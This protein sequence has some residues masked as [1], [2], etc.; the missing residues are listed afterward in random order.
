M[1]GLPKAIQAQLDAAEVIE[2][3]I[4]LELNPE[5]PP[6]QPAANTPEPPAPPA[7][8]PAEPQPAAVAPAQPAQEPPPAA[9]VVDDGAEARY[10][11]LKGK[12]DA[13]VPRLHTELRETRTMV[14]T[15]LQ[16]R[17]RA[18]QQPPTPAAPEQP[19]VSSKD[20]DSFGADL[21]E[22][23]VRIAGQVAERSVAKLGSDLRKEF[24]AVQ[25]RVGQV[26]QRQEQTAEQMFWNQVRALVSDWDAVDLDPR[27]KDWL[28]T[29]PD[30]S[31]L[32]YYQLARAAIESGN[33]EG[34]ARIVG[35]WKESLPPQA[36]ADAPTPPAPPPAPAPT[37]QQELSRQVAPKTS[38]ASPPPPPSGQVWTRAEYEQVYD[39]RWTRANDPAEVAKQQAA[40]DLAVQEGRV[41]F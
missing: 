16:E 29:R 5:A 8:A 24:G 36:P 18:A 13:E 11:S 41:R 6:A 35:K 9:P 40:A 10:R 34:V 12:Y 27:W 2:Q 20:E 19:L 4:A 21:M 33:P 26:S 39:P 1:A 25:E 22:A 7:P 14:Q 15:L 28:D 37:P 23:M 38:R 17:A 30:F 3:Q 31:V 32:S